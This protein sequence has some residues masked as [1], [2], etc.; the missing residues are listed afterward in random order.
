MQRRTAVFQATRSVRAG[1]TRTGD[2]GARVDIEGVA[3]GRSV[4]VAQLE[5]VPVT[6]YAASRVSVALVNAGPTHPAQ[7]SDCPL[8]AAQA[9]LCASLADLRGPAAGADGRRIVWP[10]RLA[11]RSS[12]LLHA[13]EGHAADTDGDGIADWQ[14]ACPGTTA[15]RAVNANG[16]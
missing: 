3:A 10:L 15:R 7:S 12:R 6:H 2:L 5:V 14:D 13:F 4:S 11:P 1:D 9:A 16:C 8:P